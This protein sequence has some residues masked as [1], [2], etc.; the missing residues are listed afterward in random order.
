[1]YCVVVVIKAM[2][3][4]RKKSVLSTLL[5]LMFVIVKMFIILKAIENAVCE[6]LQGIYLSQ[7]YV[8]L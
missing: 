6:D 3:N 5:D 1:L 4:Y 2:G 8:P 7:L